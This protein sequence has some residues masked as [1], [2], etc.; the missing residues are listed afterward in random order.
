MSGVDS[1]ANGTTPEVVTLLDQDGAPFNA[2]NGLPVS[3]PLTDTQ[4]RASAVP[5]MGPNISVAAAISGTINVTTPGTS[6]QG[7]NVPLTNGVYIK[8]LSGN[9]GKMYIGYA[10]GD[11]RT[12]YELGAGQAILVQVANLNTLWF[13]ASV[14]GEKICWLKG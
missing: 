12:G 5:V 14:G 1:N 7:G 9:T 8:A 2:G 3:G 4:L 10:T 11:N 13:D 6:I